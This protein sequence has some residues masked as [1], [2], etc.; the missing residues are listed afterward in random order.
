[1]GESMKPSWLKKLAVFL[2]MIFAPYAILALIALPFA[3]SKKTLAGQV[4]FLCS[5]ASVA[6]IVLFIVGSIMIIVSSMIFRK[7][8]RFELLRKYNVGLAILVSSIILWI[9]LAA[10]HYFFQMFSP[11]PGPYGNVDSAYIC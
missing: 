7:E 9:A 10:I 3:L 5:S 11:N 6:T 4:S 2:G 8:K 1:M